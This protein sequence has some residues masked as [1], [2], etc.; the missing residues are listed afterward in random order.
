M[1]LPDVDSLRCFVEAARLLNFRAAAKS[2]GLTPAAL[3]QRIRK[4]ED[5]LEVSL[6][7]RTTRKVVL[8]EAGLALLPR[9]HATL[10]AAEECVGAARGQL[11]PIERDLTIGTRHEL[12][13][14]WIIPMLPELRAAFPGVTFHLYVGSGPDLDLRVRSTEID[15]AVSSRR[16]TDPALDFYKLH[17]EDYVFVGRPDLLAENPLNTPEDAKNHNLVDT[18]Q[19]I[20]LFSYWRDAPGGTDS[21]QFKK[22]IAMGTIAIIRYM[23]LDGQGVGVL[24]AYLVSKDLAEGRLVRIMPTVEARHDWFRLVFRRDDPRRI[25]FRALAEEMVR[26]PLS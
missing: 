10:R 12:G 19:E 23:I 22:L 25:L 2:V 7:Q 1:M 18:S 3:G 16:I 17:S 26:L 8:T 6:F 21:L 15:C 9:A 20:A 4:L 5:Q 13:L 24:P 11:G 14:S